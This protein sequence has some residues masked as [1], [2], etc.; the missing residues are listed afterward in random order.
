MQ[1]FLS[2]CAVVGAGLVLVA[3]C[4][5]GS[6]EEAPTSSRVTSS[7]APVVTTA[8]TFEPKDVLFT[9]SEMPT[10]W[11]KDED[12]DDD[13]DAL[14]DTH[15]FD[16]ALADAEV[17][18]S[19]QGT[20]PQLSQRVGSFT[21][22]EATKVMAATKAVYDACSGD[23]NGGLDWTVAPVSFPALGEESFAY[24]AS[25]EE[26]GVRIAAI[27]TVVRSGDGVVGVVYGDFGSVDT[28]VA[29]DYARR[30][31]ARLEAAQ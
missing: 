29:E 21:P 4:G 19:Q 16:S 14:C 7:N 5:G 27:F 13:D 17:T 28:T 25:A 12:S 9:L 31:V 3:G 23:E 11:V 26:D 15:L 18:F 8:A 30:A 20:I 22:G 6:A 1:R 24:L 10:G 2:V